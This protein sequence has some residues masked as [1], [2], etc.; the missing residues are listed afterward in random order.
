MATPRIPLKS[1]KLVKIDST[2]GSPVIK[3][4]MA[5]QGVQ[6]ARNG[7]EDPLTTLP[8]YYSMPLPFANVTHPDGTPPY[9]AVMAFP[10]LGE[11]N[12]GQPKEIPWMMPQY[13]KP[14]FPRTRIGG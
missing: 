8:I 9:D 2:I 1:E 6:L 12:F 3:G 10:V 5:S 7:Q 13:R 4:I 14:R 11:G